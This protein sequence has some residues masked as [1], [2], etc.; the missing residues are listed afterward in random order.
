ME[1]YVKYLR[2]SRFDRDYA[3]LSIEETLKRHEAILDKLAS[4]RGYHIAKTYYEV[5]SGESI[6]ARPEIQKMLEEVSLGIY[7]GVLVVDVERLARGNGADQAYISQVFQFSGTKIVTP[8]KVY[9]PS[10]EFDEEYFEFGL[11]MSRR[12][13][14]TINRR[15]IRGRDSSAAEG[16]YINSI[17]PY[18]YSRVKLPNEKGYT[19]EPHPEEADV[20]KKIFSLFLNHAGTKLIANYLNDHQIPTRHG[21]LWT[22][23][24]ITNI[25]T[26]PIYMGKIRRGWSKQVKTIE[27]GQVKRHIKRHKNLEDYQIYDGLHPALVTE[28]EFMQAQEIRLGR[29]PSAKVKDEFVLQNA[30]AGLLYCSICG[31]RVGRTTTSQSTGAIPRMRC[32]NGRNCHNS[33]AD[34][35]VVEKEIITALRTWLEG[36]RVKI[37]TVG[38]ADDI[39]EQKALL[40]K[41][42]QELSKLNLQLENAFNLVEQGVYTLD[43]FKERR[44]KL[45][46]TI[47]EVKERRKRISA[48]L[49][50]LEASE[51]CQSNLIPQTETLLESYDSMTNQE[52]NDLLK[53]ILQKIEYRKGADG[54]IEIDLYP[55]LPHL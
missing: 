52:R 18:G 46:D 44:E 3:E 34:Y 6:A 11:F 31:K 35:T 4:D 23:S 20:I 27:N 24:T 50:K 16:K 14:K 1:R 40:D 54:K 8:L 53:V 39:A 19:L 48:A 47:A 13:Y 26:N 45:N 32:V 29:Q 38:F 2:K 36:Y 15:L 33:S 49:E 37:D 22:Y 5:V 12:E 21:D 51:T 7:T 10:N 28:E 55:R 17:A 25:I 30:F 43:L 41:C 42:D 9:D